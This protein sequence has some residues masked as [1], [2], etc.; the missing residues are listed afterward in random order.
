MIDLINT[1]LKKNQ[2]KYSLDVIISLIFYHFQ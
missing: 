1:F 2:K